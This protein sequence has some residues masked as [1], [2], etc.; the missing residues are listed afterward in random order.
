M[1]KKTKQTSDISNLSISELVQT[2]KEALLEKKC[3]ELSQIVLS[4]QEQLAGKNEEIIHLKALLSHGTPVIGR[5]VQ[6]EISDEE[7]IAE[8]QLQMLKDKARARELTLEETKKFDLLVKNKRLVKGDST[9]NADYA[10]LP[11]DTSKRDLLKIASKSV[12]K[13]GQ[14][15]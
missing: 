14:S 6:I 4:L 15:Q 1:S 10:K 5:A 2:S 3:L 12:K 11:E 13:N 7:A 8:L 9:I